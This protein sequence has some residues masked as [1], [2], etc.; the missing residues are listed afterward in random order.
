MVFCKAVR[1]KKTVSVS[2]S[3]PHVSSES[4][5]PPSPLNV[6]STLT[7]HSYHFLALHPSFTS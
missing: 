3:L 1:F 6:T 7:V 5:A 2:E 4:L